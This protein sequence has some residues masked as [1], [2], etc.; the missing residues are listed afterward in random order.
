MQ[1]QQGSIYAQPQAQATT[2]YGQL[3]LQQNPPA[4]QPTAYGIPTNQQTAY[5]Q[6]AAQ[7]PLPQQAYGQP[8][9]AGQTVVIQHATPAYGQSI[10][11]QGPPGYGAPAPQHATAAYGQPPPSQHATYAQPPQVQLPPPPQQTVYVLPSAAPQ[12]MQYGLQPPTGGQPQPRATLSAPPYG[13]PMSPVDMV[14]YD[15]RSVSFT[16]GGRG[17]PGALVGPSVVLNAGKICY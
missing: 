15:Q 12:P 11:Q 17:P 6:P 9:G 7:Q 4:A 16:Q 13:R 1:Q 14:S 3:A 10:A 2:V 8:G 5:G